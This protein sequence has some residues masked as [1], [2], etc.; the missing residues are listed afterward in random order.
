MRTS[1]SALCLGTSFEQAVR[2]E[3]GRDVRL[4]WIRPA[5]ADVLREGFARLSMESRL[6]RFFAPLHALSDETLRY[7][8][9]V[10]GVDHAALIAVSPSGKGPGTRDEGYGVARFIR[11]A[12]DPLSAEVAVTVADDAQGRGLGRRLVGTLAAGAR[13]RGVE[14]FQM[15]VLGSNWRVRE[16]LRRIHADY[17]RGDGQ[18]HEYSVGTEV[19]ARSVAAGLPPCCGLFGS[20]RLSCHS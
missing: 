4:R 6:M 14:T 9:E 18:V 3:D 16:L 7:L 11:S 13:E 5:D 15:S 8:T 19:L 10:D 2:L 17:R 20:T 1:A 12:S